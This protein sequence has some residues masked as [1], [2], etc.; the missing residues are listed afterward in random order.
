MDDQV[1]EV[2]V[3]IGFWDAA[4]LGAGFTF[5]VGGAIFVTP[6]ALVAAV[7]GWTRRCLAG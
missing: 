7:V 6:I 4:R 1:K 3:R 5:G 2:R